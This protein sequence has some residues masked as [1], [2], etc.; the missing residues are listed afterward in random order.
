MKKITILIVLALLCSFFKVDAQKRFTS[1]PLTVGDTVPDLNIQNV[2]NFKSSS[3]RL[4]DYKNKLIILDFW[5]IFCIPCIEHMPT[6]YALQKKYNANVFF[7]PVNSNPKYD[8]PKKIE[9]FFKA[10][11]R[12]FDLPSAV[13]DSTLWNLFQPESL[14]VYVWIKNGIVQ[15]ITEADEVNSQNIE[16]AIKNE[17]I[18]L[19]Q[20]AKIENDYLKPLFNKGNE[21]EQPSKYLT[22]SLLFP[23]SPNLSGFIFQQDSMG[24]VFRI[25][26]MNSTILS[27]LI[28]ANP[29]YNHFYNRVKKI[30]AHPEMLS[31]DFQSDSARQKNAYCYEAIFPPVSHE[32][33]EKYLREDLQRYFSF[34]LDS[35][36]IKDTCFVLSLSNLKKLKVGDSHHRETNIDENIGLPIYLNNYPISYFARALEDR[37]KIPV[38]SDVAGDPNVW[39]TLPGDWSKLKDISKSLENQGITLTKE[40]RSVE[41]LVIKDQPLTN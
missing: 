5:S 39:L 32:I 31:D 41:Y 38:L 6:I 9:T 22:R 20:V 28:A 18:I 13:S 7:L 3:I 29:A 26:L 17:K 35:A 8:S 12:A 19:H 30:T 11:K 4:A 27:L 23:Y 16:R 40:V 14:G 25:S 33:A 24:K 21:S 1:K 34:R 37:F 15:Q 36:K 2:V 10:R